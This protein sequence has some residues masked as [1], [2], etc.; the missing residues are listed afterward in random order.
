MLTLARALG[1]RQTRMSTGG[2]PHRHH[3][4]IY[5]RAEDLYQSVDMRAISVTHNVTAC[6]GRLVVRNCLM[7]S[8]VAASFRG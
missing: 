8:A 1:A 3:D 7:A 6:A 5:L 4:E 2:S